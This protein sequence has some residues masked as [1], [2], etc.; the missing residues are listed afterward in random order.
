MSLRRFK[1][2]R[3]EIEAEQRKIKDAQIKAIAAMK[4]ASQTEQNLQISRQ[5]SDNKPV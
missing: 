2:K 3:K 1:T 5:K 4:E